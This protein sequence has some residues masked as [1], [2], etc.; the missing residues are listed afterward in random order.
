[1][2]WG[3]PEECVTC[4]ETG[5]TSPESDVPGISNP[6]L[7][8]SVHREHARVGADVTRVLAPPNPPA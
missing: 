7:I 5:V 2:T 8:E 4:Q 3:M 6:K 1:M